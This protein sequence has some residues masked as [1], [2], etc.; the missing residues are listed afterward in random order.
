MAVCALTHL[1]PV[2]V[3]VETR[4][5]VVELEAVARRFFTP[6]EC[7]ELE[8]TPEDRRSAAFLR[9]WTRRIDL[10]VNGEHD[11]G[12]SASVT[13]GT[14]LAYEDPWTR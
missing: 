6:N 5:R 7:R 14:K 3:D 13:F 11:D 4:D 2:G 10:G 8:A 1:G 12:H 9:G